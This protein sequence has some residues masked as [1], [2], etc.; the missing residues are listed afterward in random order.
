[1]KILLLAENNTYE[2]KRLKKEAESKGHQFDMVKFS[3]LTYHFAED[4]VQI[5]L[6]G[7]E[8]NIIAEFDAFLIRSSKTNEGHH[9]LSNTGIIRNLVKQ[10]GKFILN[11]DLSLHH[12]NPSIKVYTHAV[13]ANQG[14]PVLKTYVFNTMKQFELQKDKLTF[15]LIAKDSNS[16]HGK[17][18][19]LI[20]SVDELYVY[21]MSHNID[22]ILLQEFVDSP[23]EERSDIR[24]LMI[25][26]EIAGVFERFTGKDRITTNFS[27]GGSIRPYELTEEVIQICKKLADIFYIDYA[28]IDFIFKDGKPYVLEIN[29]SAQFKGFE[30]VTNINL[31]GK[32]ID[33]IISKA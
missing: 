12:T 32:L 26:K 7:K 23:T 28:G 31:A 18:V 16:S 9:Y 3:D 24:V 14:I 21:F 22:E 4:G 30:S 25:G 11:Y 5:F 2:A 29:R 33:Y 17:G 10:E 20:E 27:T 13:L 19:K 6:N 15:P 8:R 1:M